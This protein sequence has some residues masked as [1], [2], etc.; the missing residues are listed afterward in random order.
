M[1]PF[2]FTSFPRDSRLPLRKPLLFLVAL[3]A[4]TGC[5]REE[6]NQGVVHNY[7]RIS[8]EP[9]RAIKEPA[10][11][12]EILAKP[13]A[14]ALGFFDLLIGTDGK[15]MTFQPDA[16]GDYSF[17]MTVFDSRGKAVTGRTYTFVIAE[18][19]PEMV[20]PAPP[21]PPETTALVET[22]DIEEDTE[23]VLEETTVAAPPPRQEPEATPE[24]P[25]ETV[26][27]R[28]RLIGRIEG[29]LTIQISSWPTLEEAQTQA[30]ELRDMGFDAYVQEAP[31]QETDELWYRV[32]VGSFTTRDAAIEAAKSIEE[33]T[34]LET[35]VDHVRVDY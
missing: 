27:V 30:E 6:L 11:G 7:Y 24:G 26:P 4:V 23:T 15:E 20:I 9:P 8:V 34:G 18:A 25:P 17:E 31:F 32:R 3:V 19:L 14:S 16:P 2:S 5:T 35:W 22:V 10:I 28:G 33:A 21:V 1:I 29:T 12:W 13:P